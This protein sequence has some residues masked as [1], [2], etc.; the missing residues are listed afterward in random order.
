M[1]LHEIPILKGIRRYIS[2]TPYVIR[3]L[4]VYEVTGDR[5]VDEAASNLVFDRRREFNFSDG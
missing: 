4:H 2:N 5:A 3:F 1:S